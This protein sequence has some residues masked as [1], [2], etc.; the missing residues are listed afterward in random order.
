MSTCEGSQ[1]QVYIRLGSTGGFGFQGP[2]LPG[3]CWTS[4][5]TLKLIT[6]TVIFNLHMTFIFFLKCKYTTILFCWSPRGFVVF[7]FSNLNWGETALHWGE[8]I[9]MKGLRYWWRVAS[10]AIETMKFDPGSLFLLV[11]RFIQ[12]H[13]EGFFN[14]GKLSRHQLFNLSLWH[15]QD[16][17]WK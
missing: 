9:Y 16:K 1:V 7:F 14:C 11:W 12:K 15:L 8:K 6:F 13:K 3:S 17:Q 10:G 4:S 2:P 5:L